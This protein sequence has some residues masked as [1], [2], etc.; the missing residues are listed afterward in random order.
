MKKDLSEVKSM[1]DEEASE[2][3]RTAP[4]AVEEYLQYKGEISFKHLVDYIVG[5]Y[6][7]T[8]KQVYN[9]VDRMLEREEVYSYNR[10]NIRYI[11]ISKPLKGANY[12]KSIKKVRE[13]LS[14]DNRVPYF[15]HKDWNTLLGGGVCRGTHT[16]LMIRYSWGKSN[17]VSEAISTLMYENDGK[18]KVLLLSTEEDENMYGVKMEDVL[19][20]KFKLFPKDAHNRVVR[21][22]ETQQLVIY[23]VK[24]YDPLTS[25]KLMAFIKD[26][27]GFDLIVI[28]Y[29]DNDEP[30]SFT[31][32][33]IGKSPIVKQCDW[34]RDLAGKI[35]NTTRVPAIVSYIQP[36]TKDGTPLSQAQGDAIGGIFKCFHLYIIKENG[37]EKSPYSSIWRSEFK[38]SNVKCEYYPNVRNQ[39]DWSVEYDGN[40]KTTTLFKNNTINFNTSDIDTTNWSPDIN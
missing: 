38:V 24:S 28:D 22:D 37:Y 33:K 13:A 12:S 40:K 27:G 15:P 17:E 19:Q 39:Q 16:G 1:F 23:K 35:D 10:G 2:P 7:F 14:G 20:Y 25:E 34:L 6:D 36:K 11:T 21:W 3:T 5:K 4:E 31:Q 9:A 8:R 18:Y 32:E 26:H 29:I 30:I